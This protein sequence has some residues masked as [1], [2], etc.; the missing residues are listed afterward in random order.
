[1]EINFSLQQKKKCEKNKK[2]LAFFK[3]GIYNTTCRCE[4]ATKNALLAQLVEHLTLN[5]GVRGS[6][7]RRRRCRPDILLM[8]KTD[9]GSFYV[10]RYDMKSLICRMLPWSIFADEAFVLAVL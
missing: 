9:I 7:P 8:N 3:K 1:M 4:T 10:F 5:Q 6:S 2:R